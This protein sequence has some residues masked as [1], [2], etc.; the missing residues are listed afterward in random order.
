MAFRAT[1]DCLWCG[2]RHAVRTP[3]DLEGF[4]QLCP[5]CLGRAQENGFLRARLKEA[6]A[7]RAATM[8][9][10]DVPTRGA[11]SPTTARG[12][13]SPAT[14]RGAG[15]PTA[16]PAGASA[17]ASVAVSPVGDPDDGY[18]RR[19]RYSR[20]TI[21]DMAWQT[22][23]DAATLWVDGL[24]FSGRIVELAAGAGWWSP[25]LAQKGELWL[26]D[27]DEA[28]LERA[29]ARLVAHGLRAHL[30]RRDPWAEP[31]QAAAPAAGLFAA[32]WL[33]TVPA[34]R[35]Q[36]AL[37]LAHAWLEP[38][39]LFAFIEARPDPAAVEAP[40]HAAYHSPEMLEGALRA[41]GFSDIEL[42]PTSRFLVLGRA[43][44]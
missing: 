19:G 5:D 38:G 28:L 22:D 13:G 33:E 12:A 8:R 36:E 16:G 23:L 40:G 43:H 25:L 30:H 10:P 42:V 9:G 17:A 14:A 4:A 20:G 37:A 7:E 32:L 11:G 6:L 18:L 34:D 27:A 15:S 39:G 3:T 35:L 24:P 31:D 21:D 26:Y 29:R 41:A 44:A 2:R 1:F